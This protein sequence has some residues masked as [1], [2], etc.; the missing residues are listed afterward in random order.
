MGANVVVAVTDTGINYNHPDIAPNWSGRGYDFVHNDSDPMD[1]D[2]SYNHGTHVSG[3]IAAA[4]NNGYGI[5][6]VAPAAKL[7]G[8]KVMNS[9]GSGTEADIAN[10]VHYAADQGAD[11]LNASFGGTGTSSLMADA[12]NYAFSHGVVCVVAA[13]NSN[14]DDS[15]TIPASYDSVVAVAAVDSN[16]KAPAF[17]ITGRGSMLRRLV[18]AFCQPP[19]KGVTGDFAR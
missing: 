12:F 5:I 3:T 17:P 19:F 6:G 1:D 14:T 9:S 15:T 2:L 13:G 18:S 4:G 8:V 7:M 16:N 10:G 11:V